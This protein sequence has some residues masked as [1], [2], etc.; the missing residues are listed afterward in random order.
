[1]VKRIELNKTEAEA[2]EQLQGLK[3]GGHTIIEC[4]ACGAPLVD[5]WVTRPDED[6]DWSLEANCPHCG[7]HSFV[8]EVHGGFHQG[9]TDY[10]TVV[11]FDTNGETIVFET[12]KG[13][14]EYVQ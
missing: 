4:S 9:H 1:M 10:T 5:I 8:V 3:D 7:D 14:K 12:K 13:K 11:S 2:P 6:Y